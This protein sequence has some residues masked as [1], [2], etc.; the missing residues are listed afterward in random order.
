MSTPNRR[1]SHG[2]YSHLYTKWKW[3]QL[4]KRQLD[5]EPLCAF[6]LERGR[7]TEAVICDHVE[8]HKGDMVKFWSGPF[9]SLCKTCHD[10]TKKIME[11]ETVRVSFFP[12]WL[13]PALGHLTIVF[14]PPGSGK[15]TYVQQHAKK[16]DVIIDL[17]YIISELTGLP[18][19]QAG[20]DVLHSAVYERN[21]R[22]GALARHE[23]TAWFVVSGVGENERKWWVS[24]LKPSDVVKMDTPEDECIRRVKAD[25][26]RL[27]K[28]EAQIKAIR[29]WWKAERGLPVKSGVKVETGA[30]G[31]PL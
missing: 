1:G 15:S 27:G 19:Y 14:G 30:D 22:L 25:E 11:N 3:R 12:D 7:V 20:D 17:D 31:W 18:L 2:Q 8:P 10:T 28:H 26:R 6:C 16:G 24:K 9:Q 29:K 21:E 23:Y 13:M 5:R 4:R